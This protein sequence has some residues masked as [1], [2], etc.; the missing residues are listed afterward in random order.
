MVDGFSHDPDKSLQNRTVYKRTAALK[1]LLILP[2][3]FNILYIYPRTLNAHK[4]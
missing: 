3:L 4:P 2:A 1:W